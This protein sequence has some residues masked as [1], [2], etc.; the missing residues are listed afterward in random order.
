MAYKHMGASTI[1]RSW[2]YPH[3]AK[4]I[5]SGNTGIVYS[6]YEKI[7]EQ[8][9][10]DRLNNEFMVKHCRCSSCMEA[11]ERKERV[12]AVLEADGAIKSLKAI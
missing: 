3:R 6:I 12:K 2:R 1:K 5:Y 7:T 10:Q 9:Q 11:R 4:C 8:W